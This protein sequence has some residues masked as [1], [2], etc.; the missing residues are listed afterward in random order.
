[1]KSI[2][3]NVHSDQSEISLLGI[4]RFLKSAWKVIAIAGAVGLIVSAVYLAVTP[5]KFEATTQIAMAQIVAVNNNINYLGVNVEEPVLLISRLSSPTSFSTNVMA[6]CGIAEQSNAGLTLSKSIK[7][8]IPKSLT[9]VVELK[10]FGPS[11]QVAERCNLAIFELIKNTQSQIVAPYIAEAKVRLDD[12]IERLAKARELVAKADN[13]GSTMGAAYFST[14]DEIRYLLDQISALKNVVT[15]SQNLV[16]RLVAPIYVGDMPIAPKKQNIFAA[17][18]FGGIVLGLLVA[19]V[20]REINK[21]K[22]ISYDA[23]LRESEHA[24]SDIGKLES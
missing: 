16:T 1:M 4:L 5:K 2:N 12:D 15:S 24:R 11:P 20:R 23:S 19:L 17:G 6:A 21:M 18:I 14:R 22:L 13:S 10:T 7:L 9:N 8:T 3:K